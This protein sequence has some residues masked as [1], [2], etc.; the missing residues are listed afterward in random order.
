MVNT[1]NSGEA[2]ESAK[3]LMKV[4]QYKD[5]L[6]MLIPHV[7]PDQ[8]DMKVYGIIGNALIKMGRA[9]SAI[10]L[11][12]SL[13]DSGRGNTVTAATPTSRTAKLRRISERRENALLR[14][15][16]RPRISSYES[17]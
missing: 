14:D 11:L 7:H 15:A 4:R 1:I 12:T 3:L 8:A 9:G 13:H 6:A 17:F 10:T 5:V 16:I 2:C